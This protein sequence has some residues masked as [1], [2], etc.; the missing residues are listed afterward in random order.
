M[1]SQKLVI[2]ILVPIA[3]LVLLFIA[4]KPMNKSNNLDHAVNSE[5]QLETSNTTATPDLTT[6]KSQ[7]EQAV[8]KSYTA[9]L[10][11]DKGKITVKLNDSQTP[12]TVE[13]FVT[14][15]NKNFYDGTIFHRVVKGFMIQGGDP[16]GNGTGGPGYKFDDEPF[17]GE[18]TRGTIAM[19]NSGPNT[20]GSQFFIMH[21]DYNLPKDYVVFGKV[22]EGLDV[23]DEIANSN[24]ESNAGGEMSKPTTPTTVT[25]VEIIENETI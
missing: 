24:V 1:D 5:N 3:V 4:K 18:Y 9:I 25:T 23:V 16:N 21:Q 11:T 19:A 22:I 6:Q 15:A 13:N 20:N 2:L 14:L 8:Q 10:N 17:T 7:E 12:K